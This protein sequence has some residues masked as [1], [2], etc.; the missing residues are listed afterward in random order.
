[1]NAFDA[2]GVAPDFTE[3]T[4]AAMT[5]RTTSSFLSWTS[6]NEP[7]DEYA[8]GIVFRL[9]QPPLANV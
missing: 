8:A 4:A 3:V 2:G 9:S 7:H 1:L 5:S 6:L